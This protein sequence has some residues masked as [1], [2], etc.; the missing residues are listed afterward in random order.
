[1]IPV[2]DASEGASKPE[3]VPKRDRG[4]KK[5]MINAYTHRVHASKVLFDIVIFFK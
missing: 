5:S 4:P 1:M 2:M 3:A